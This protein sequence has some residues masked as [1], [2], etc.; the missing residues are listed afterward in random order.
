MTL[1]LLSKPWYGD[2]KIIET[3][4]IVGDEDSEETFS[5]CV[6][7]L[8]RADKRRRYVLEC[9][10][11]H[12]FEDAVKTLARLEKTQPSSIKLLISFD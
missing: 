8:T 1:D 11:Q 10:G 2:Q 4:S 6:L 12:T 9:G 3:E 7:E 5:E